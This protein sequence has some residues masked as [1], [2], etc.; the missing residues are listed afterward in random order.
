MNARSQRER[1]Y[2]TRL[3]FEVVMTIL[4]IR[5]VLACACTISLACA[6]V[7]WKQVVADSTRILVNSATYDSKRNEI[8]ATAYDT[9]AKTGVTLRYTGRAMWQYI[10]TNSLPL[11][12]AASTYDVARDRIV[13]VTTSPTPQTW[14]WDG[15]TW[16]RNPAVSPIDTTQ[17][18]YNHKDATVQTITWT[19]SNLK[20]WSFDGIA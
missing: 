20:L 10:G 7:S 2:G 12:T 17:L 15:T 14:E 6:Q 5:P 3:A 9:Q 13:V 11:V 4:P 19:G 16:A 8:I 1:T 18:F